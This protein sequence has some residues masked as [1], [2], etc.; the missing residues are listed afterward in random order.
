M[1]LGAYFL[2]GVPFG[3]IVARRQGV[4]ITAV[5]SGNIGATNVGRS[6]GWHAGLLVFLLDVAKGAGATWGALALL[7]D[8]GWAIAIGAAAVL[9]HSFSPFLRFRGGKGVA[10]SLG[11]LLASAPA[12]A[13]LAFCVFLSCFALTRLVS[14][15]SLLATLAA[16]GFFFVLS[17]P[18]VVQSVFLVLAI[19]LIYRHRSNIGRLLKGTEPKFAFKRAPPG[20]D[21]SGGPP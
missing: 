18:P 16:V 4:N 10:T 19:F 1:L 11:V 2:G 13:L 8:P 5:G 12:V 17:T 6:L 15:S 20:D 7:G 9:G 21:P 3:V 14:L